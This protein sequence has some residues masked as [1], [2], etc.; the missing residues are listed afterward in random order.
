MTDPDTGDS[1]MVF[2]N[3]TRYEGTPGEADYRV[4]D[5]LEQ[6]VRI[7]I[8]DKTGRLSRESHVPTSRLLGSE[9]AVYLAELQ[10]R[11]SVPLTVMV[12]LILAVP[13]SSM[14][15]R[16]SKHSG[17]VVA[18]LV[19]LIY[20]NLLGTARAWVEQG[21]LPPYIGL[22]WVHLLPLLAAFLLLK[23]AWLVQMLK[24]IR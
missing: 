17:M 2:L 12:L 8:E 22:W 7:E 1:Y 24:R 4:M 5:F 14:T 10:W 20:Y 11:L 23:R 3:G 13:L 16:Q 9:D 18:V 15:P 21:S 19:F 6:G